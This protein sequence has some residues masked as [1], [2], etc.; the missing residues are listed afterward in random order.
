MHD[1]TPSDSS[2]RSRETRA[3]LPESKVPGKTATSGV[4][5]Q[6][7]ENKTEKGKA[8]THRTFLRRL[9]RWRR[10]QT[11]PAIGQPVQAQPTT[12]PYV[13]SHPIHRSE[14]LQET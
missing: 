1:N 6:S 5:D 4:R 11:Y 2:S 9:E 13:G 8:P 10:C 14:Q 12:H 3:A 7:A